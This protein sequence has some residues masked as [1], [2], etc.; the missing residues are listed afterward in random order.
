MEESNNQEI[1]QDTLE[2]Q[3]FE[4]YKGEDEDDYELDDIPVDYGDEGDHNLTDEE[5]SFS[6]S[7]FL[8]HMSK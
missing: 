2:H 7:V 3:N 1:D 6:G 5:F 8:F 4:R